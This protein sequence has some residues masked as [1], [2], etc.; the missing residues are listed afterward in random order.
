[1]QLLVVRV[2]ARAEVSLQ[3]ILDKVLAAADPCER[4]GTDSQLQK[5]HSTQ[6]EEQRQGLSWSAGPGE[7]AG[8]SRERGE[9]SPRAGGAERGRW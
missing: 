8:E 2:Y 9:R 3:P 4:G 6:V 5:R 1:M 7:S